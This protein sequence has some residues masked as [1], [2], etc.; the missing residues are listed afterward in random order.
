VFTNS[1]IIVLVE[2]K[3]SRDIRNSQSITQ[4]PVDLLRWIIRTY[5]EPGDIILDPSFGSGATIV[6]AILEGRRVVGIE[7]DELYFNA[8]AKRI[9]CMYDALQQAKNNSHVP[10]SIVQTFFGQDTSVNI[11]LPEGYSIENYLID[12]FY[13]HWDNQNGIIVPATA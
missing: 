12:N 1:C 4:K 8:A 13:A 7:R 5:S 2:Q 6:A 9:K 3:T 10:P 11:V